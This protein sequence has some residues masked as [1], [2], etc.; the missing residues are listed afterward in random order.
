MRFAPRSTITKG[1]LGGM[2][3][4]YN[5]TNLVDSQSVNYTDLA[6]PGMS[7]PEDIYSGG[8]ARTLSFTIFLSDKVQDGITKK[9]IDNI[10]K[11][12]PKKGTMFNKPNAIRF[13]FGLFVADCRLV[14]LDKDITKFSP[15]L[16]PIEANLTVVLRVIQ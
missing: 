3:F 11:Y 2:N 4:M 15:S 8:N 1:K 10:E 6:T 7:Y 14:T 13:A 5:P 9:F 12:L 16:V